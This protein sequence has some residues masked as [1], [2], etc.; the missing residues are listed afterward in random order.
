MIFTKR[1]FYNLFVT[2]KVLILSAFISFIIVV[3]ALIFSRFSKNV[4]TDDINLSAYL[5]NQLLLEQ[6]D[7]LKLFS[8]L[9]V[10]SKDIA[11]VLENKI[12][13]SLST[14]IS[15]IDNRMNDLSYSLLLSDQ[16]EI[17]YLSKSR[18]LN[19]DQSLSNEEIAHL[20][21]KR[22]DE[23]VMNLFTVLDG[24]DAFLNRQ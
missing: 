1:D 13:N 21:K 17:R 23:K 6:R 20:I 3:S 22:F 12:T 9:V 19:N 7:K 11:E 5:E 4:N 2:S 8:K 10:E 18:R 24:E 14:K 16:K 15:K